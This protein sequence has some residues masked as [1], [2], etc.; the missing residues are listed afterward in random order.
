M[1]LRFTCGYSRSFCRDG[2]RWKPIKPRGS[3]GAGGSDMSS[4]IPQRVPSQVPLKLGLPEHI[5]VWM[6]IAN[7][8]QDIGGLWG[9]PVLIEATDAFRGERVRSMI[10][11]VM[12]GLMLVFAIYHLVLYAQ[13]RRESVLLAF[14]LLVYSSW[15][16]F[17]CDGA[18]P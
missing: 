5:L 15:D 8:H 12:V 1:V 16:S 14:A 4:T 9:A 6:Q 7:F 11:G 2:P 13:G 10:D 18:L 3:S 17:W